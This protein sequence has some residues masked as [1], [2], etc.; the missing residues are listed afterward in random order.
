MQ[1]L[2]RSQS[3]SH[4]YRGLRIGDVD[5]LVEHLRA[6]QR[7]ELSRTEPLQRFPALDTTDVA[8][9]GHDAVLA[10]N[11]VRSVVVAC[12]HQQ[13]A[14]SVFG[15]QPSKSRLLGLSE[16]DELPR[17]PPGGE[18]SASPVGPNRGILEVPPDRRLSG[19]TPR[20]RSAPRGE[21][22]EQRPNVG[23]L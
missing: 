11:P 3:A 8:G 16:G 4:Q 19:D 13:A 22:L 21:P 6:H 1:V 23:W 5:S 9:D 17:P 15:Q 14:S 18:G 7:A 12:E 10:R 20:A 2:A